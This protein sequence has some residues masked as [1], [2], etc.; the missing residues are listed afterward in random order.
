MIFRFL[1]MKDNSIASVADLFMSLNDD[2]NSNIPSIPMFSQKVAEDANVSKSSTILLLVFI[3]EYII[4]RNYFGK[5]K[6]L[7]MITY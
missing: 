6:M 5:M 1:I 3:L 2:K 4:Q 7:A